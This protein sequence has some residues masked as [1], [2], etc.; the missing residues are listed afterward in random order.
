MFIC[1]V[2]CITKQARSMSIDWGFVG[3]VAFIFS[4]I[5]GIVSFSAY[6]GLV[7]KAMNPDFYAIEAMLAFVK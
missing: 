2:F 1:L 3:G 4:I 6:V 5:A 7:S